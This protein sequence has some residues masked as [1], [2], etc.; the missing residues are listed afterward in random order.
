MISASAKGDNVI[1]FGKYE[2]E[3]TWKEVLDED[4]EY[5]KWVLTRTKR[6]HEWELP[7]LQEFQR[8][9]MEQV[10]SADGAKRRAA[11]RPQHVYHTE[12]TLAAT[13]AAS[14][15]AAVDPLSVR[16]GALS[17]GSEKLPPWMMQPRVLLAIGA[18]VCFLGLIFFVSR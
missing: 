17:A 16:Q 12:D 18:A 5:C 3:L 2:N 13:P 1:W 15:P 10:Q 8:W 14:A 6:C 9:L 11:T 4:P 7:G